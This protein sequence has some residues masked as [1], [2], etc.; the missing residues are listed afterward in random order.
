MKLHEEFN[1]LESI[2]NDL[3]APEASTNALTE[4]ITEAPQHDGKVKV[5]SMVDNDLFV[6][7]DEP[8]EASA[9]INNSMYIIAANG[10]AGGD[11][12]Y[13]G[14][15]KV[16]AQKEYQTVAKEWREL[17]LG[18]GDTPVCLYEYS[19]PAYIFDFIR[20][21]WEAGADTTYNVNIEELGISLND[22]KVL[23]SEFGN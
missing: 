22:C 17:G 4:Y 8:L 21:D 2:W 14:T 11:I 1:L 20:A 16:D 7:F 9:R 19:G 10:E 13:M 15:S 5:G 18:G 12:Y 6:D 3:P 23:A